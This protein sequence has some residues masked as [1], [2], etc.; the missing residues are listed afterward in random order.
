MGK[1]T[2]VQWQ[3]HGV[4]GDR[5]FKKGAV[6]AGL[7]RAFSVTLAVFLMLGF[8][9]AVTNLPVYNF[10]TVILLTILASAAIGGVGAGAAAGIRGWQHGGTT[11]FIYGMLYVVAGYLVGIPVY[12]PVLMTLAMALLGLVGGIVGVN[13]PTVRRRA[14]NRRYL[15]SY[16]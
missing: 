15:G 7:V 12:D 11:G 5:P 14:V 16:K 6:G 1:L 4:K 10:S 8:V 3:K 13:L 2:I 9:V